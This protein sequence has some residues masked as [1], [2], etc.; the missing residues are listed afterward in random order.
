MLGSVP[1][2]GGGETIVKIQMRD[3]ELNSL[4]QIFAQYEVS[5]NQ[6]SSTGFKNGRLAAFHFRV[7]IY[8]GDLKSDSDSVSR[9]SFPAVTCLCT[10]VMCM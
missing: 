3:P 1:V 4:S 9:E 5:F 2:R 8:L 7:V 6:S 10:G